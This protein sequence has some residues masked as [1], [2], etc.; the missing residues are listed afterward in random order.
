MQYAVGID[1]GS[2]ISGLAKADLESPIKIAS[3]WTNVETEKL[4]DFLLEH[5]ENI[6]LIVVGKSID[7]SGKEN[8]VNT[9]IEKL[10]HI[11]ENNGFKVDLM[12]ERFTT[13]AA[14][15][16]E[17]FIMRKTKNRKER[18]KKRVDAKAATI[19]L[20]NYLDAHFA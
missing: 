2:K 1:Y 4:I 16:E 5:K 9:E 20:Q 12:D 8:K 7:L 3:P 19:I 10:L 14:L 18:Q 13:Q 17:R 6:K 11:L 15:A